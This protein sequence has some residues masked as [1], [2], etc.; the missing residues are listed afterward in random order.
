M[1]VLLSINV[2]LA[3]VPIF[4]L[5]VFPLMGLFE[6]DIKYL[7]YIPAYYI[8]EFIN[9]SLKRI[10]NR[11]VPY[12]L[13]KRPRNYGEVTEDDKTYFMGT[14]LIPEVY[15]TSKV[16]KQ[17]ITYGFPSGHSQ[18]MATFATFG[19]LFILHRNSHNNR[20]FE[21]E[22]GLQIFSLWIIALSVLWQRWYSK[23]H[24]PLQ[25]FLGALVGIS[26]GFAFFEIYKILDIDS[27][28]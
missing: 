19:T 14:G 8:N 20:N 28:L 22:H 23:C 12:T 16:K 3:M 7:L 24:T 9:L 17:K 10:S 18:T 26:L 2:L 15:S 6:N 1:R 25:I 11:F 4:L 13:T 5:L 21:V 27:K